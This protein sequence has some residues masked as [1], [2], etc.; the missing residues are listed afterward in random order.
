MWSI[1]LGN[2][3]QRVVL[4]V[5]LSF[6]KSPFLKNNFGVFRQ[7]V[8]IQNALMSRA[9]KKISNQISLGTHTFKVEVEIL[10]RRPFEVS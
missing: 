1:F 4:S 2:V 5:P 10:L 3:F 8:G 7:Q 9:V 6:L